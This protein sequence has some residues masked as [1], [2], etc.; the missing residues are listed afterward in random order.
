[1]SFDVKIL[2]NEYWWGGGVNAGHLM[3]FDKNKRKKRK[4]KLKHLYSKG[5]K[6]YEKT[7]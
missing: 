6:I 2:E 7:N 5:D 4:E 1:M 3:P